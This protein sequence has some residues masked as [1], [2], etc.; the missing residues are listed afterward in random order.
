MSKLWASE[1]HPTS[2]LTFGR[3][4]SRKRDIRDEAGT[5]G[6][7]RCTAMKGPYIS[8][9]LIMLAIGITIKEWGVPPPESF[10]RQLW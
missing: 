10:Q 6:N 8:S 9:H 2:R 5:L 7:A 4:R 1:S 3:P